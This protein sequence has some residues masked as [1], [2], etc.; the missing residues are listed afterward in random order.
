M[1]GPKRTTKRRKTATDRESSSAPSL[2]VEPAAATVAPPAA[3][4]RA[5][6]G[7]AKAAPAA[8][9]GETAADQSDPQPAAAPA[10]D[11]GGDGST[12]DGDEG[13]WG[14]MP[15]EI[16]HRIIRMSSPFTRFGLGWLTAADLNDFD[17][18]RDMWLEIF[19]TEWQGDLASL[20]RPKASLVKQETCRMIRTREMFARVARLDWFDL[21]SLQH[22]VVRNRWEDLLDL[23]NHAKMAPIAAAENAVWL[24]ERLLAKKRKEADILWWLSDAVKGSAVDTAR[25]LIERLSPRADGQRVA[26]FA[27]AAGS[28]DIIKLL[29]ELKPEWLSQTNASRAAACGHLE[30][31]KFLYENSASQFNE[32]TMDSAI[33]GGHLDIFVYLYDK[34]LVRFNSAHA[35]EWACYGG[36]T[37]VI[38]YLVEN[39]LAE[40]SAENV[41]DLMERGNPAAVVP[42][43]DAVLRPGIQVDLDRAVGSG[44][45]ELVRKVLARGNFDRS[46]SMTD[47]PLR[48]NNLAVLKLLHKSGITAIVQSAIEAAAAAGAMSTIQYAAEQMGAELPNRLI[49]K[50]ATGGHLDLVKY[51][52]EQRGQNTTAS[53]TDNAAGS[54]NLDLVKWLHARPKSKAS[55]A[56]MDKAA[57]NGHLTIVQFLHTHRAEGCTVKAMDKAGENGH[58]HVLEF[59]HKHRTEGFTEA[60]F[61]RAVDCDQ[62]AVVRWVLENVDQQQLDLNRAMRSALTSKLVDVC[63]IIEEYAQSKNI[64][65]AV[66]R[67]RD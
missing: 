56:G 18:Q 50:A 6:K 10:L 43:L 62:R 13:H 48:T 19:E 9:S 63:N 37:A 4:A 8:S 28:I 61:R 60:M 23:S 41:N 27:M 32:E 33:I 65:L 66:K 14:R 21:W 45:A 20:P 67:R 54:G 38:S 36:C 12:D 53:V 57:A 47:V 25:M 39:G 2:S 40:L 22:A 35:L 1:T 55:K 42:I 16:R 5:R 49:E 7:R 26:F 15:T 59:L 44:S 51:L 3:P 34:G 31:V 64:D 11:D 30:V 17:G 24:L 46:D 29:F 58:A 52:H